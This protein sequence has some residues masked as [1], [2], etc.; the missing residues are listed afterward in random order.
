MPTWKQ[1]NARI[2][3]CRAS[4]DPSRKLEALFAQTPDGHIAMAL[5]DEYRRAGRSAEARKWYEEAARR[6]PLESHKLRARLALAGC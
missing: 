4:A 3:A 2:A 5:G 6:Y 1:T